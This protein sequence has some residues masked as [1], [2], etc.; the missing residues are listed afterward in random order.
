MLP[1]QSL[2]DALEAE[3]LG[4]YAAAIC[5]QSAALL[6]QPTDR[7][8]ADLL[9]QAGVLKVG[10]RQRAVAVLRSTLAA[11]AQPAAGSAAQGSEHGGGGGGGHQGDGA[12][13]QQADGFWSAIVASSLESTAAGDLHAHGCTYASAD[14]AVAARPAPPTAAPHAAPPPP[15]PHAPS[16]LPLVERATVGEVDEGHGAVAA[17]RARAAYAG[18]AQEDQAELC[19]RRGNAAFERRDLGAAQR[20][21]RRALEARPADPLARANLAACC[22]TTSPPRPAEALACLAPLLAEGPACAGGAVAAKARL[23]AGR[24]CLLLGRVKDAA[25]HFD[26][27]LAIE[28]AEAAACRGAA[29]FEPR[30]APPS[31][32]QAPPHPEMQRLCGGEAAVQPCSA[33]AEGRTKANKLLSHVARARALSQRGRADEALYLARSVARECPHGSVGRRDASA[34]GTLKPHTPHCARLASR[35]RACP[36]D[37]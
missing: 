17:E 36:R 18:G 29:S 25:A 21:Y 32:P 37:S 5:G 24:A 23:R 27:S 3:G 8:L 14:E 6:S 31:D 2:L 28:K 7:A 34:S 20:W 4:A 1:S 11:I 12:I 26:A 13:A 30:W 22:L 19:R 33:A 9:K 35:H 10:H 15:S 16:S